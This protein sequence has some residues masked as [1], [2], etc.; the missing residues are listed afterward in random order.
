M[1]IP[2]GLVNSK[3]FI[4]VSEVSNE[5][6]TTSVR[7][8]DVPSTSQVIPILSSRIRFKFLAKLWNLKSNILQELKN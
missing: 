1:L 5:L 2:Q 4:S 8:T 7:Y 6:Y 3:G